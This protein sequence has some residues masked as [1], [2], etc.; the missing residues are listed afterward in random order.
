MVNHDQGCGSGSISGESFHPRADAIT[1]ARS[2][3]RWSECGCSTA[4]NAQRP[5]NRSPTTSGSPHDHCLSPP[6]AGLPLEE[7]NHGHPRHRRGP[8]RPHESEPP[9]PSAARPCRLS[10]GAKRRFRREQ[11]HARLEQRQLGRLV[12]AIFCGALVEE[13]A[14]AFVSA[15]ER[16]GWRDRSCGIG[17]GRRRLSKGSRALIRTGSSTSSHKIAGHARLAVFC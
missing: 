10:H 17:L 4:P 14:A 5:S 11:L 6:A 15:R 3:A 8:C 1:A 12:R 13:A 16:T 2:C 9:R 7:G